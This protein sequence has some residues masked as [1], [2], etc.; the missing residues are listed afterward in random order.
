MRSGKSDHDGKRYFVVLSDV[1]D[2]LVPYKAVPRVLLFVLMD[3]GASV[4]LIP[5]VVIT[6]QFPET[7]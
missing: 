2:G 1:F 6:V 7:L 5:F 3:D 4:Y